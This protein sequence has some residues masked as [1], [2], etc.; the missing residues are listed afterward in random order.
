[1]KVYNVTRQWCDYDGWPISAATVEGTFDSEE[2]A[3]RFI[4]E[5][6]GQDAALKHGWADVENHTTQSSYR[7]HVRQLDVK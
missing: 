4:F 1:M 2:K 6:T 7:W 3:K 5:K